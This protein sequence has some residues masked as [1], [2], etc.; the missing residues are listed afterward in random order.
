MQRL[1]G[2][3]SEVI[4]I[5]Q[6]ELRPSISFD[7]KLA[8]VNFDIDPNA[9]NSSDQFKRDYA[10]ISFLRKWKGFRDKGINPEWAAFT[11]WSKAEW[12]CFS[13]NKRLYSEATTGFYSVAPSAIIAAQRKISQILGPLDVDRIAELCRF[14]N[15]ATADLKRGATH[16]EKSREPS[17]TFDAIP[18]VCRVLTGDD[19]MASLVGPLDSLKIIEANRMVMVA[20]TV[21]TH[22]PIA[23]EPTLNSY[24][25]QGVGRYIRMRLKRFGVDLDDQTINQD[26]ARVAQSWSLSTIDLSSASD[27]LC[28]NLVKLLLPREWFELLDDL[29]CKMTTYKGKR[30]RLSK[31]SSM[32]NA[33]TFELESLIFYS[34]L[35]A[36]CSTGVI[37]VYGDDLVIHNEDYAAVIEVLDWAGFIVNGSKSFTAGSRF[38]ESC[39][40]HYF[41]GVEVTPVYQ[42][43]VCSV[44]HDYVRLHNRLVRAGIR[45]ELRN[46]FNAAAKHVRDR[47][48]S[49]LGKRRTPGVG[50]LVEYDE[51]FVKEDFVWNGDR[52]DRVRVL[53]AVSIAVDQPIHDDWKHLAYFAR[54]LRCPSFLN[55][56]RDGQVA[57]ND[58]SKLLLREKYHWRSACVS[59]H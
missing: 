48:R 14:G 23:A 27:T 37:S 56:G 52:Q 6:Q 21:K 4:R 20:K 3:E 46:E 55:T 29:R 43:D 53:S 11:A 24:V 17:V 25:Q 2:V 54:K 57:E 5:L 44:S 8:Y 13:T 12:R 16:A 39:G 18:W 41:D 7:D 30:F 38:Y 15:G 1:V 42:K 45:L 32:G 26:L 51:Y 22:R 33:Y 58:G 50:P 40:K 49:I 36:V 34:L 47:C 35:S 10:Y 31:F 19:Y 9:Y 59:S 28:T